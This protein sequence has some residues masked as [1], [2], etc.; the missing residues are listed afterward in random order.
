MKVWK[1]GACHCGEVRIRVRDTFQEALVCNCS[2][3]HM[4]G[5]LH[6]IVKAEDFELVTSADELGCYT[7]NTGVAKHYFCKHCGIS[8][9]YVPRSHPDGFDVN[10]RCMEDVTLSAMKVS[11]FDGRNWEENI[12]EIEGYDS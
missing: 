5:F 9:Y 3:C 7:F 10:L 8:P 2:I 11:T 12:S 4:K 1:E 6:L